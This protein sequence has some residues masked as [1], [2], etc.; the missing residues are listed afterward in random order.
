[1]RSGGARQHIEKTAGM[2]RDRELFHDRH[3]PGHVLSKAV[4]PVTV[5]RVR[6]LV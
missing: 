3:E 6:E 4:L 2:R 5:G 1:M